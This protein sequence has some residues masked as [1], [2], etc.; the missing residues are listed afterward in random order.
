[1][2]KLD[3]PMVEFQRQSIDQARKLYSETV[4]THWLHPRSFCIMDNPDGHARIEGPCGDTM[5]IF[6]RVS[7]SK[8]TDASFTTNGCITSIVSGS[9]AVELAVGRD[10]SKAR[11]ISQ[12]DILDGLEGLPEESRHCALLASNT[13]RATVDDYIAS[14]REP[15]K[16]L[17]RTPS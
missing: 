11:S 17:Y 13:L 7:G 6:L 12:D 15:W 8:I 16:K 10:I 5:E 2:S 3:N 4:V 14:K 1:M 9:M